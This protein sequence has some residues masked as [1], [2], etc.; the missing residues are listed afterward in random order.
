MTSLFLVGFLSLLAQVVL[1]RELNVAFYGIELAYLFALAAWMA[2][3]AAGAIVRIAPPA[4]AA[5]TVSPA[6]PASRLSS[7]GSRALWPIAAA[8]VA[9]PV[10]VAFLRGSRILFGGVPGAYLP[11]ERQLIAL[12]V[13][14]VPMAALCGLAF[15]VAARDYIAGGGRLAK[16]YAIECAGAALAGLAATLAFRLGAQNFAVAIGAAGVGLALAVPSPRTWRLAPHSLFLLSLLAAWQCGPLD[17]RLTRW[18]HPALAATR[19]TPYA[20]VTV[21]RSGSQ[22]AVFENDVLASDSE[23]AASEELPHLAALQ[24]PVRSRVL[25]LGGTTEL[26]DRA[27]A[28]H[29]P[30]LLHHVELDAA[31]VAAVRRALPAAGAA[32]IAD[33]RAILSEPRAYDLIVIATAEPVSGQSNRLYTREFFDACA[34]RLAPDGVLALRLDV[35]QNYLGPAALL[36]PASVAR[37]LMGAFPHVEFLPGSRTIALASGALLP[38]REVVAARVGERRLETRL[39]TGAYV[40]YLYT[41]DRRDELRT[42]FS[43][44]TA[45][46]NRDRQPIAYLYAATGWLSK[47]WPALIG[48]NPSSV[49]DPRRWPAQWRW[50]GAALLGGLLAAARLTTRSRRAALALCAGA[51][52]MALETVVLLHYQATHGALFEDLGVLVMAFMAGSAAGASAPGRFGPRL[53][54]VL[55]LVALAGFAIES[56]WL[57]SSGTRLGLGGAV[58]LLAGIGA[59]VAGLFACA[60]ALVPAGDERGIGGVYAAD[61][62][63]GCLGSI[64]ASALLVPLAGM[65]VTALVVAGLAVMVMVLS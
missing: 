7:D 4:T 30:L 62:L 16:A 54:T 14:V 34:R 13:S 5:A 49:A 28:R 22:V 53:R 50:L 44:A 65:D 43:A 3:T 51:A 64:A 19:D 6:G 61:V 15:S 47:F 26:M 63:G 56:W 25:L 52:G 11:L 35:P 48:A 37:A 24:R 27:L 18:N 17:V 40:N 8:A 45:P 57:V 46:E 55:L 36:R 9:L 1:L 23:S 2:G 10:D 32:Q 59:A 12:L 60:S 31:M 38:P 33:P 20:R 58:S 39:V 41:N 42:A 29:Q 21:T